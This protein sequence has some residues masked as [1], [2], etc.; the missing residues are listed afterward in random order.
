VKTD[1][2]MDESGLQ[3]VQATGDRLVSVARGYLGIPYLWGGTSCK[4]FDCSGFV[5][6]VYRMNNREL[7]RDANQMVKVGEPVEFGDDY[8]NLR[9][10]DLLFF[11]SSPERITHVALYMGDRLFIHSSGWVH[12]NSLDSDHPLFNEYRYSTLRA[13]RRHLSN[14]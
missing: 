6:T 8:K 11:G 14:K 9:R 2:V 4:A 12:I 13:A 3:G 7:P 1:A 5:Q 10:G